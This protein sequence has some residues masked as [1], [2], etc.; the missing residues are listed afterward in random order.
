VPGEKNIIAD[1]LSRLEI[2]GETRPEAH[3][4]EELSSTLYCFAKEEINN[5]L[6]I[7]L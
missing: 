1:A 6:S 5:D 3:F 7:V 4:T 2:S